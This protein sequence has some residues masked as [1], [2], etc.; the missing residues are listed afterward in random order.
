MNQLGRILLFLF[1]TALF[2]NTHSLSRYIVRETE[3]EVQTAIMNLALE[4]NAKLIS[5]IEAHKE[6][7]E[8]LV[9]CGINDKYKTSNLTI[10]YVQ[11]KLNELEKTTFH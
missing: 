10:D 2:T 6:R 9:T 4:M 5:I 1:L 7:T 11:F 3:L 8:R